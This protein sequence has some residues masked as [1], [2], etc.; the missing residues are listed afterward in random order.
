MAKGH[1]RLTIELLWWLNIDDWRKTLKTP[2]FFL[3]DFGYLD[4]YVA[5]MKA[6]VLSFSGYDTP[7]VDLTHMVE[8]GNILQ[9]AYHLRSSISNLPEGSVILAVVD[10][11]VG[12]SR[13]GLAAF[14]EGRFIVAPDNGLISLLPQPV[15]TWILPQSQVNSSSTFHGRDVFAYCAARLAVNPGWVSFLPELKAPVKLNGFHPALK[16]DYFTAVILHIDNF[17]NCILAISFKEFCQYTNVT[18]VTSNGDVAVTPVNSYYQS[19]SLDS[20]LS[21]SGSQGFTELALNGRS[22][23]EKLLVSPGDRLTL[24]AKR[25]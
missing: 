8:P 7:L 25:I 2:V 16:E 17:G 21:L 4:T 20:M 9:A 13:L 3:S 15:K 23:A 5:Q 14:W 18:L 24:K 19:P 22:A 10:P 11:G 1:R 12:S 6:V